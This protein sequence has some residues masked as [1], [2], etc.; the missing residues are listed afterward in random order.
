VSHDRPPPPR[1]GCSC[2][3]PRGAAR[4]TPTWRA[5]RGRGA[6]AQAR[7]RRQVGSGARRRGQR[8]APETPHKDKRACARQ[9]CAITRTPAGAG[10]GTVCSKRRRRR[11]VQARRACAA[12]SGRAGA[13]ASPSPKRATRRGPSHHGARAAAAPPPPPPGARAHLSTR[14]AARANTQGGA[15]ARLS[16]YTERRRQRADC[17]APRS[18]QNTCTGTAGGARPETALLP[19]S[20]FPSPVRR[21]GA[22]RPAG[23]R[24]GGA[25]GCARTALRASTLL[26]M[27]HA[28]CPV[29]NVRK[30]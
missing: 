25:A 13:R 4:R 19:T 11:G 30:R 20:L 6:R 22:H 27:T 15:A 10:G 29:R 3:P 23:R 21:Y 16:E 9:A 28:F 14:P 8:P 2:R 12:C 24:A 26:R 1:R 18:N 7:S 17:I 5:R